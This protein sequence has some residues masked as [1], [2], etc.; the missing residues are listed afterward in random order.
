MSTTVAT[1]RLREKRKKS[2]ILVHQPKIVTAMVL[3]VMA[4]ALPAKVCQPETNNMTKILPSRAV[5]L[6][7]YSG[8]ELLIKK[9]ENHYDNNCFI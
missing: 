1:S 2:T 3:I 6:V 7:Y 9:E 4:T 8:L 5:F